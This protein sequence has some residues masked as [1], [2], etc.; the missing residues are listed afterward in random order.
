M[1]SSAF[2]FHALT[3]AQFSSSS[4]ANSERTPS[5]AESGLSKGVMAAI[6]VGVGL[7]VIIPI[8][9]GLVYYFIIRKKCRKSTKPNAKPKTRSIVKTAV[10][11]HGS[12]KTKSIDDTGLVSTV[13]SKPFY[14]QFNWIWQHSASRQPK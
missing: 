10:G 4:A 11:N 13:A 7:C 1:T 2:S 5:V 14:G 12:R 9:C 8:I 3:S 6:I